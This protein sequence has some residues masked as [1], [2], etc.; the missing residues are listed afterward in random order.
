M[1]V[2][3]TYRL[4][5][6]A[7]FLLGTVLA[8]PNHAHAASPSVAVSSPTN[9][10]MVTGSVGVVARTPAGADIT[11]VELV[12]DGKMMGVSW[13]PPYGVLWDTNSVANGKHK[14]YVRTVSSLGVLTPSK[15]IVVRV[16]NSSGGGLAGTYYDDP[17]FSGKAFTR[18]DPGVDFNWGNGSPDPRIGKDTFSV[19]WAG[20]VEA[21]TTD[22]YTFHIAANDNVRLYVGGRLLVD[23][24][25]GETSSSN[26]ALP[27][28]AGHRYAIKVEYRELSGAAS[29]R[30]QWS[31]FHTA[32]SSIPQRLLSPSVAESSRTRGLRGIYYDEANF[33][34]SRINRVDAVV[35]FAW[36]GGSPDSR[37]SSDTFSVRWLGSL[38][39]PRTGTYTFY[40]RSDDGV[41]VYIGGR[42]ILRN[43]HDQSPTEKHAS[44][45]LVRGHR[46]KLRIDYYDNW[47]DASMRLMW[48][49]PGI[50]KGVVPTSRLTPAAKPKDPPQPTRGLYGTYFDALGFEQQAMTRVDPKIDFDWGGGS[51]G[52]A[53]WPDTFSVRWTGFVTAPVSGTYT[54]RTQS[55]DG[56]RLWVANQ[57]L[58]DRW[59]DHGATW[60]AGKVVLTAG[61]RY[62]VEM[63]FYENAGGAV[64]RLEWSAA[65]LGRSIVPD[66][67]LTPAAP[68]GPPLQPTPKPTP[69]PSL[70]TAP[71]PPVAG[72][73]AM[74][75]DTAN[76]GG[77]S[78]GRIDPTIDFDWGDGS[79][80]SRIGADTFSARWKGE[81]RVPT[82]G[83]YTFAT[84]TDDGVRLWIAGKKIID[85]WTDQNGGQQ[86]G[87]VR[88]EAG[89]YYDL[90]MDYY[91]NSGGALARLYWSSP[92]MAQQVIPSEALTS[93]N[94]VAGAAL[95]AQ[96][97][98]VLPPDPPALTQ[99]G[100]FGVY[101]DTIDFSGPG[102]GRVDSTV[103]FDWGSGRPMPS[104]G[105]DTFSV[106]WTGT[107]T[108][109]TSGRYVLHTQSDD[110]VRLW[111]DGMRVIDNWTDHG[112]TDNSAGVDLIAG[113]P[114]DIRMDMYENGGGAVAKL[115]WATPES[116]TA[117][118]P[119]PSSALA[120]PGS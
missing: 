79:P 75:Y 16:A 90:R 42:R 117:T 51:P 62:P 94:P 30:L 19:R 78:V 72:L 76:F 115:L 105:A 10:A 67:Y 63:Q 12:V 26:V 104:I 32:T 22:V 57:L 91:E 48:K 60:D 50:A 69:P 15:T 108:A 43:W 25:G 24:W 83:F 70:I 53:I 109:P 112:T 93:P 59:N 99:P 74:Y 87:T 27:L 64:A 55:D 65:G 44:I 38:R 21:P 58:I 107:I 41:R 110:G 4:S 97:E 11:R 102:T 80:D 68:T 120:T 20:S 31:S 14:L 2:S 8:L 95:P 52:D 46:Y 33:T 3:A 35:N 89:E 86:T 106:R 13:A 61:Q 1:I 39:A 7:V 5:L 6:L 23:R 40:A 111:I 45:K 81:I 71:T 118:V 92:T 101:Y 29:I 28:T 77:T 116:P 84:S 96:T 9:N 17:D 47:G 56:V 66:R 82:T 114:H 37:I 113:A 100:L 49:G 54:F 103:N 36:H 73:Y 88:L 119:V 34:G 18:I 85:A 98:P